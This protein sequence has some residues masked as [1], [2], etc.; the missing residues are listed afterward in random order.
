MIRALHSSAAGMQSQQMSL[1]VIANNLANVQTTAFKKSKIEF[2]DVLYQN[3]RQPGSAQGA[4]NILPTG[5]EI[6][7]GSQ[8]VATAKSFTTG[9]LV[10]TG[11]PYNVAIQGDGFFKVQLLDGTVAYTRDGAFKLNRDGQ[12]VTSDGLPLDIPFV[13]PDGTINLEIATN[14]TVSA[15]I[16]GQEQIAELGQI[17]LFR[18][19]NPAGLQS[20]GRNLYRT[21]Q[22][23]GDEVIG[24]PGENGFGTL[25][26]GAIE[27]SNVK[28]IEEMVNMIVAQRAFEVNSKAIKSADEMMSQTNNLKR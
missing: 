4:A 1:D 8:A 26:Q 11:D 12:I 10:Q 28:V 5:L 18:F 23:A 25:N 15:L 9:E 2:Q 3:V 7:N 14:G 17:Q 13:I 24:I 20:I 21:N 27:K 19:M 6:G 22:A 16:G